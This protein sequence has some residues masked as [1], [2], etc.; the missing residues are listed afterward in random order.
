VE[1]CTRDRNRGLGV[2]PIPEEI[3]S[4]RRPGIAFSENSIPVVDR[5]CAI[6]IE[7]LNVLGW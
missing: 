4:E 1:W 6:T 3:L 2:K 5:K 7:V